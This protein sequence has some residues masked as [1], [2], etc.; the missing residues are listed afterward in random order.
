VE[1]DE[2]LFKLGKRIGP[3]CADHGAHQ[4]IGASGESEICLGRN[5]RPFRVMLSRTAVPFLVQVS[6]Q[7]GRGIEPAHRA[8]ARRRH[9]DIEDACECRLAGQEREVRPARDP[10]HLLVARPGRQ[11]ACRG[12][13]LGDHEFPALGR[14]GKEA[15]LLVREVGIEGGPGHSG[16]PHDVGDSHGQ[17]A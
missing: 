9:V 13:H 6:E 16:P 5:G 8:W 17:I 12:H 14:R 3:A 11:G 7:A 15:V 4:F 1:R 2:R 10:E